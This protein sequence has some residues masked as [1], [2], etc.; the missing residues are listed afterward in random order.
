MNKVDFMHLMDQVYDMLLDI[1]WKMLTGKLLL[2]LWVGVCVRELV[3]LAVVVTSPSEMY[4]TIFRS[5][6]GFVLIYI[7]IDK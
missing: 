7:A 6:L 1:D 5:M 3:E 2:A 4:F